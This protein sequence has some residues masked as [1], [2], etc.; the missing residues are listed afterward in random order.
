MRKMEIGA[1][2]CKD[3]IH[4]KGVLNICPPYIIKDSY[5][6]TS[7]MTILISSAFRKI[8]FVSP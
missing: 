7:I 2:W 5:F 6:N 1:S 3:L 4:E 8:H